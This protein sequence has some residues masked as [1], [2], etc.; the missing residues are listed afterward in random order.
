MIK[1]LYK[2]Y[3][4]ITVFFMFLG[5]V[6]FPSICG[7]ID[8]TKL[9]FYENGLNN[10]KTKKELP[11]SDPNS[12]WIE[13]TKLIALDGVAHDVFGWSV[14]LNGDYAL[15]GSPWDY[16]NL[17]HSGSAYVF[18]RD[19]SNWIQEDKL[20]AL[21]GFIGDDFGCSVYLD[22]DYAIIG[23]PRDDDNGENSG[24]AYIFKNNGTSWIEE[25]KLTASDGAESDLFGYYVSISGNY[26]IIVHLMMMTMELCLVQHIFSKMSVHIG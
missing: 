8:K 3:C 5:V 17:P 18:K 20:T 26:A 22:G 6:F 21:D 13:Q 9:I 12:T 23:A 19:G 7:N 24:S 4:V 10:L 14:S 16:G 2:K 25:Q 15:I 1:K 11:I